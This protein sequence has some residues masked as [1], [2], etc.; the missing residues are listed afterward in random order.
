MVEFC[1]V[2]LTISRFKLGYVRDNAQLIHRLVEFCCLGLTITT[3][4]LGYVRDNA[5]LIHGLVEFC[6]HIPG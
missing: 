4:R 6:D 3:F 5:Q 1:C 2:G